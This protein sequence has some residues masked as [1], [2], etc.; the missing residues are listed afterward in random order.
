L[1]VGAP[2][3]IGALVLL[4]ARAA[5]L[6]Y[7]RF[8]INCTFPFVWTGFTL[9]AAAAMAL[10]GVLACA[11]QLSFFGLR[12]AVFRTVLAIAIF[13]VAGFAL[14]RSQRALRG[15]AA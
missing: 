4:L 5:V 6:R 3:G 1:L 9:L 15:A 13:P 14:G 7:R 12:S 2:V 8:F 11:I 10:W